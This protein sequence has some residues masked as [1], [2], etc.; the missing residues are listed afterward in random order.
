MVRKDDVVSFFKKNKIPN[1]QTSFCT[2]FDATYNSYTFDN[3]G[4][5]ISYC[6]YEKLNGMKSSGLT[7]A[8]WESSHPNWNKVVIVPVT[9]KTTSD[10][11]GNTSYAGV[12]HDMSMSS[13]RLIGGPDN[14]IKMQILYSRFK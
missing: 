13:A 11:Y 6:R 7:E 1:N 8:Q 12:A 5:L 2:A 9:V 3:L 14:P 4:H 10:T